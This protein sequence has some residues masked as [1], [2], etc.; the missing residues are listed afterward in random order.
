MVSP[1]K[2]PRFLTRT[3]A[4]SGGGGDDHSV[5]PAL[6]DADSERRRGGDRRDPNRVTPYRGVERR[7]GP[8]RSGELPQP[9]WQRP[10]ALVAV[11]ALG[12]A[13]GLALGG[14]ER[15]K[16]TDP[17]PIAERRV[18]PELLAGVERL[19]DEAEALTP[20]GVALDERAHEQWLP[21]V[22]EIE[23]ALAD[24]DTPPAIRAELDAT[25]AALAH[26]GVLDSP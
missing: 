4:V 14:I 6:G 25:L 18:D 19:R 16:P 1:A 8:R 23:L 20:A 24:P 11:I 21:R 22:A 26:A 10:L 13:A 17:G 3:P 15:A 9:V 7:Q 2:N 5:D 12:V